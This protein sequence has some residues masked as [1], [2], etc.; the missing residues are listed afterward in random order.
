LKLSGSDYTETFDTPLGQ[1]VLVIGLSLMVGGY[2]MM[3]ALSGLP[4]EKRTFK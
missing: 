4:R 3:R 2:L 1:M